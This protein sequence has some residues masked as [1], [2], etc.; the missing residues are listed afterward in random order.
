MDRGR[1]DDI[2]AVCVLRERPMRG[3]DAA[4]EGEV[5]A[6]CRGSEEALSRVDLC[7]VPHAAPRCGNRAGDSVSRIDIVL[8]EVRGRMLRART[9]PDALATA[10]AVVLDPPTST[11]GRDAAA[12]LAAALVVLVVEHDR[13]ANGEAP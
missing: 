4:A 3:G 13:E 11:S 12:D 7:V 9:S 2:H 1:A 10:I 6:L 5:P 8:A